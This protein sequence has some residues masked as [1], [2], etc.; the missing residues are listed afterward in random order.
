VCDD[1]AVMLR[2]CCIDCVKNGAALCAAMLAEMNRSVRAGPTAFF[3]EVWNVVLQGCPVDVYRIT[4]AGALLN[5]PSVWIA[6]HQR[7]RDSWEIKY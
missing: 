1:D 5:D 7:Y 4:R 3:Y 6:C 2:E